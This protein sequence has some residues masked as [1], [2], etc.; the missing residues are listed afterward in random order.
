M[1][2]S[3]TTSSFV[4]FDS[5]AKDYVKKWS[6][7]QMQYFK[8][9]LSINV[10]VSRARIDYSYIAM[11]AKLPDLPATWWLRGNALANFTDLTSTEDDFC[12]YER[13]SLSSKCYIAMVAK[14]PD[15]PATW[16]LRG[17]ALA[18]FSDLTSTEDDFCRYERSSLSSE[19]DEC[20]HGTS[21]SLTHRTASWSFKKVLEP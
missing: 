6:W 19:C 20:R 12:R 13:S 7:N 10:T 14:L 2:V 4:L 17:N 8:S 1:S 3:G 15:L 21:L 11:V 16:W 9:L 5:K 18:N